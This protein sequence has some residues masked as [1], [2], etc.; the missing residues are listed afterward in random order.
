MI[1]LITI[2]IIIAFFLLCYFVGNHLEGKTFNTLKDKLENM[3]NGLLF[4]LL[5]ILLVIAVIS[6]LTLIYIIIHFSLS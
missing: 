5:N 3:L 2:L 4:I 1:H 6:L